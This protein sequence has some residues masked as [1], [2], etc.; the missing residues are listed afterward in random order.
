ME[1]KRKIRSLYRSGERISDIIRRTGISRP[2]ISKI[3]HSE[4]DSGIYKRAVQP[5]PAL[6]E[7]IEALEKLLRESKFAKPKRTTKHLFEELQRG[8][9]D[10]SYSAVRRYASKWKARSQNV[11]PAACVP[12][13]FAPG[14]AY[15]FDWSS[16]KVILDDEIISVKVAQFILC[17]SRKKFIYIY[18]NET[19]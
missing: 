14:E 4:E 18:P 5:Y 8:G 12:L 17:Y 19:Q 7:H 15:Q 11:S 13:A 16:D 9:Y 6:G 1:S 10:G 2:T 3:I